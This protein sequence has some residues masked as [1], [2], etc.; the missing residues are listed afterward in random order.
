[1][2]RIER[3]WQNTP[4]WLV[5]RRGGVGSSD[6]PAI[7]GESPFASARR[8]WQLKTGRSAEPGETP[9][10][11]RGRRLEPAARR[12]Y[13]AATGAPIEPVCLAHDRLEWMRASLDGLSFDG[14]I[15]LEIKC[16]INSRDH[17]TALRGEPPR[18]YYAQLQHQ[19][20]VSGADELHYWSFN[21]AQGVLVR[22][23]PDRAY[24]GRLIEAEERFWRR[25]CEDCW[26][27]ENRA[28]ELDLG[29]DRAWA[30]AAAAYRA[31][32]ERLDAASL[33]EGRARERLLKLAAA[34]RTFGAGVEVVRTARRGAIDYSAIPELRSVDLEAYRKPQVAV[35]KINLGGAPGRAH[36]GSRGDA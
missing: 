35:V 30:S 1:M 23:R 36:I 20:E 15:A 29:A 14:A 32:K 2:P 11:R 18:H 22:V 19:L 26:P 33:A 8:L 3:I 12:A 6:A 25:V 28:D 7:M 10:M 16:P 4:Q 9:A 17:A 24:I 5:W 27:E 34:P 21:G 31:A 13:E